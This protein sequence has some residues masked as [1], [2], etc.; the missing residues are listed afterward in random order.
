MMSNRE[1][2]LLARHW[3]AL[4][5][6]ALLALALL[7]RL[8]NIG[9][10]GLTNDEGA[11][12]MWARLVSEGYSLY[13]QTYTGSP[14]L[15]IETLALLFRL[16]G[17][18][19][20]T[21]RL[22]VLACFALLAMVLSFLAHRI[23][24][25]PG[26]YTALGLAALLPPLFTLSRQVMLEV[27]ALLPAV[28]A[29][30]CG[31][32]A[33]GDGARSG[34]NWAG[35]PVLAGVLL[36]ASLLVKLLHPMAALPTLYFLWRGAD[37]RREAIRRGVWFGLAL[38]ATLAAVFLFFF[39]F[40]LLDQAI[41]FRAET[42]SDPLLPRPTNWQ[43]F[44]AYAAQMWGLAVAALAG[45]VVSARRVRGQAWGMWLV[46][47]LALLMGYNPVFPHHFSLL[48]APAILL[49]VE[50]VRF[51]IYDLRFIISGKAVW[52]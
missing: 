30:G 36:A 31:Y 23:A 11:Y 50:F 24:G 27:P 1:E 42:R 25:W 52:S 17:F 51:T 10:F 43:S 28:A 44:M 15:F 40:S 26:A 41:R 9:A 22:V 5:W 45:L 39:F 32:M 2:S 46:A 34:K 48:L 37:S 18:G 12:L 7:W 21:G 4:V 49:A 33:F 13:S 19:V 14:P 16:A 29:V 35:W 47:N 20:V 38:A 6:L 8:Q 3:P